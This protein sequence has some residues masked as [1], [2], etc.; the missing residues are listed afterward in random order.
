MPKLNQVIAIEKGAKSATESEI[1]DCYHLAQRPEVFNGLIRIYEPKDEEGETLPPEQQKITMTAPDLTKLFSSSLAKLF[2]VSATKI[3]GNMKAT[4]DVVVDGETLLE[5]VPVEYLLFMEKR[6]QDVNT[7][8]NK[9]P[10]LD[11]G[12]DW[13]FDEAKGCFAGEPTTTHRTKKVL[14][15]HVKAEATDKHQAQV[16]VY[17]ED[18]TV[19]YWKLTRFSGALPVTLRDQWRDR[20][21]KLQ[22]AVKFAQRKRTPSPSRTCR[23]VMRCSATCSDDRFEGWVMNRAYR[24]HG[25]SHTGEWCQETSVGRHSYP[26]PLGDTKP[27]ALSHPP[28]NRL[29]CKLMTHRKTPYSLLILFT[30]KLRQV[31]VFCIEVA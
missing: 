21:R 11:P 14:R 3:Y 16:D 13:H 4:A 27:G 23:L 5:N 18:E 2:D 24:A 28:L 9:L 20:V 26:I 17:T 19:G 6:L 22:A 25:Y 12:V 29:Q 7:Y 8:V 10:I 1:T 15:N 30:A 31:V